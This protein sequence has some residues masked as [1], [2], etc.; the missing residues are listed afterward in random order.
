MRGS[1]PDCPRRAA[2]RSAEFERHLSAERNLSRHTIRAYLG[3]I[4]SLLRHVAAT[5]GL[6]DSHDGTGQ[7]PPELVA[8][9]LAHL[10]G[11]LANMQSGGRPAPP[12]L[13]VQV[14]SVRS[15]PGHIG[16]GLL[17]EDPALLLGTP[18]PHRR[19]PGVLR[20]N[21]AR[22]LLEVAAVAA[23]DG[24]A[25]EAGTAPSWKC[26]TPPG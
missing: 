25:S 7:P 14:L 15:P 13:D 3:D 10:R 23:D 26:C 18:K 9:N 2:R 24:S 11:W 1:R 19:L 21:D 12:L 5:R 16:E 17:P 6:G 20:Q 22:R 8:L 4:Q